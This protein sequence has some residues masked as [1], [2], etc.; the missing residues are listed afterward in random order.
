MKFQ[1][2]FYYAGKTG[3]LEEM[4]SNE[5][6][7][8]GIQLNRSSSACSP[9][10]LAKEVST[11]VRQT[12]IIFCVGG[13]ENGNE[14]SSSVMSRVLGSSVG[15]IKKEY[16]GE[17]ED[18]TI[19]SSGNQTIL[20]LPDDPDIVSSLMPEIIK[21]LSE[22]LHIENDTSEKPA[23]E[24]TAAELDSQ[25]SSQDRQ[26]ITVTGVTAEVR[27]KRILNGLLAAAIILSLLSIVQF[28]LALYFTFS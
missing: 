1:I 7:C 26:K 4:L 24:K 17:D 15:R 13:T 9:A 27:N 10:E 22:K 3:E 19:F 25:L 11:A 6:D 23:F 28:G 16:A 18:C 21:R 5:L 2:I 14:S 20:L 8:I 12:D